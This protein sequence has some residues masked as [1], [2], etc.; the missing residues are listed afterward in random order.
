MANQRI[1][2]EYFLEKRYQQ[3]ALLMEKEDVGLDKF[4]PKAGG[5]SIKV[6][7]N[8]PAPAVDPK[9]L[10][11]EYNKAYA[12][13]LAQV[14]AQT[15]AIL[16]QQYNPTKME[17]HKQM[18]ADNPKLVSA[19]DPES[20]KELAGDIDRPLYIKKTKGGFITH[21]S[22]LDPEDLVKSQE[23]GSE[24]IEVSPSH[25]SYDAS[26]SAY[27]LGKGALKTATNPEFIKGTAAAV[28]AAPLVLGAAAAAL[29]AAAAP[30]IAP[31]LATGAGGLLV[32]QA[33]EQIAAAP[34]KWQDI[35]GQNIPYLLNFLIPGRGGRV[36]TQSN[37]P[38]VPKEFK[39]AEPTPEPTFGDKFKGI[40]WTAPKGKKP[41]EWS[42]PVEGPASWS[43]TGEPA[44]STQ[45]GVN[46]GRWSP[47]SS[48]PFTT[49]D[50]FRMMGINKPI[51][52]V[53][54]GRQGEGI[55][56]PQ[57]TKPGSFEQLPPGELPRHVYQPPKAGSEYVGTPT[58]IV[59]MRPGQFETFEDLKNSA[60][61]A[62]WRERSRMLSDDELQKLAADYETDIRRMQMDRATKTGES[63]ISMSAP[64]P[65][66]EP[67]I[68]EPVK[69]TAKAAGVVAS[70]VGAS[71]TATPVA[72]TIAPKPPAIVTTAPKAPSGPKIV[73]EP[74]IAPRSVKPST[75]PSAT[76]PSAP[77]TPGANTATPSRAA[78]IISTSAAGA[79][80][81]TSQRAQTASETGTINTGGMNQPMDLKDFED[82][83]Q[84]SGS[85]GRNKAVS[86]PSSKQLKRGT[87]D[88]STDAVTAPAKS[89]ATTSV[90][91]SITAPVTAPV[92]APAVAPATARSTAR[93]TAST[94]NNRTPPGPPPPPAVASAGKTTE[95]GGKGRLP[96]I[97]GTE[98]GGDNGGQQDSRANAP[99]N[100]DVRLRT[101]QAGSY[102]LTHYLA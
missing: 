69:Q 30:F 88:V 66:T 85:S 4:K 45:S 77:K 27:K 24:I 14:S 25:P 62:S 19:L 2:V 96:S 49:K 3:N 34:S 101:K 23:D 28:V 47:T 97:P 100:I 6:G 72:A 32:K 99:S 51:S 31:V 44:I 61:T 43:A 68:P 53:T 46:Y 67:I 39:A 65:K 36:R 8:Q 60:N 55:S 93:T 13:A 10:T 63:S 94:N 35:V 12:K 7:G 98:G 71:T 17:V 42:G 20:Y 78:Q 89:L 73:Y 15:R 74:E 33:V 16:G 26:S 79:G 75:Q 40:E 81:S 86:P 64:S 91:A 82:E 83:Q 9:Q 90:A 37:A 22:F 29:P 56:I 80:T 21:Q 58:I 87:S 95:E 38:V 41:G 102:A 59:P 50:I 5:E 92:T 76:K 57:T 52:Q 54:G 1:L 84:T 18:L 48:K 70:G 11:G